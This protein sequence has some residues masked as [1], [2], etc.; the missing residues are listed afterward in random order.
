M[1]DNVNEW[2][3]DVT[4]DILY[5]LYSLGRNMGMTFVEIDTLTGVQTFIDSIP[6]ISA[7]FGSVIL[8]S[9]VY[10]QNTST[11]IFRGKTGNNP[12][13]DS[14]HF[15]RP[16]TLQ[17]YA[18][19]PDKNVIEIECDNTTFAARFYNNTRNNNN[20][21]NF[22]NDI[23]LFR[24]L[25]ISYIKGTAIKLILPRNIKQDLGT[26]GTGGKPG[27]IT[28]FDAHGRA[29]RQESRRLEVIDA[30]PISIDNLSA[31]IYT[32]RLDA[33]RHVLISKFIKR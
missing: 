24:N 21:G 29:V 15:I 14:I 28:V 27:K 2:Q 16:A 11:Y 31:G 1:P 12:G 22:F 32:L 23:V 33:G 20:G 19:Q 3:Y 7:S 8:G 18:V 10:D 5:G 9:S 26:N 25:G 13:A 6:G 17:Q 30:D 4:T